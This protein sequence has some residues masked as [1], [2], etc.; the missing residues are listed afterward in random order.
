LNAPVS[1][2]DDVEVIHVAE[3]LVGAWADATAT[4]NAAGI[5]PWTGR[6]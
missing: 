5:L 1:Q 4:F 2:G 6:Q 3:R